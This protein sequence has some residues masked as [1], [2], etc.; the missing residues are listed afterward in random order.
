MKLISIGKN[1]ET[2]RSRVLAALLWG[3]PAVLCVWFGVSVI[4]HRGGGRPLWLLGAALFALL[5]A[6]LTRRARLRPAAGFALLFAGA[7]ALRLA[8]IALWPVA[9]QSDILLSQQFAFALYETPLSDWPAVFRANP[10]FYHDWPMHIPYQL[11]EWACMKLLRLGWTSVH[12][13]NAAFGAGACC[14]TAA[15]A[16]KLTGK[17]QA[18]AL[19]GVLLALCPTALFLSGMAV[20]QHAETFFLLLTLLFWCGRPLRRTWANAVCAGLSLALA[21]LLRPECT[22]VLLAFVCEAVYLAARLLQ[23]DR[24]VLRSRLCGLLLVIALFFGVTNAAD[25]AIRSAGLADRPITSGNLK[26]KLAVGLNRETEGRFN[27]DD[28][29]L[30]ADEQAVEDLLRTRWQGVSPFAALAVKKLDFQF[31]AYDYWWLQADEGGAAREFV[32]AH[33]FHPVTQCYMAVM[34]LLAAGYLLAAPKKEAL[35]NIVLLGFVCAFALIEVQ[36]RY[37]YMLIPLFLIWAAGA[38]TKLRLGGKEI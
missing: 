35:P 18:G 2:G 19:A 37:N 9:P 6:W 15:L 3:V 10:Y 30:A 7:F 26:Y 25:F 33:V 21:Q 27:P 24:A 13:M 22:V 14:V 31:T 4:A 23:K 11:Y 17:Q 20:N 5:A 1:A 28:Y 12:V 32:K 16:A 38:L 8:M 34:L 29:A 36:Q